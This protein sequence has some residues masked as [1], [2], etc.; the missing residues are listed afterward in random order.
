MPKPRRSK[1]PDIVECPDVMRKD[2]EQMTPLELRESIAAHAAVISKQDEEI[3]R[4]RASFDE[5]SAKFAVFASNAVRID[6]EGLSL[7]ECEM[8]DKLLALIRRVENQ[9]I[10]SFIFAAYGPSG[11]PYVRDHHLPSDGHA[12]QLVALAQRIQFELQY[13]IYLG[14]EGK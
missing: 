6:R 13:M 1:K 12:M 7:G 8:I 4:L 9:E 5:V 2:W 11:D 14:N 10:A 3:R